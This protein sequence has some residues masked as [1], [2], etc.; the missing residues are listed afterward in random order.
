[1]ASEMTGRV[2]PGF[3][4]QGMFARVGKLFSILAA[5]PYRRAFFATRTAAATEHEVILAFTSPKT[6][7]DVGANKGQFSLAVR[8]MLPSA[9]IIAFEVLPDALATYRKNFAH[10]A[11][12]RVE[13]VALSDRSG[14]TEFFVADRRDSSSLLNVGQAQ[15]DIFGVSG[16]GRITVDT[17][18]LDEQEDLASLSGPILLKIDVQGAELMVLEGATQSLKLV[19]HVYVECS[20]IE[21]YEGQAL[22]TDVVD[23]LGRQGFESCGAFNTHFDP[24]RGPIQSDCLF[25]RARA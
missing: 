9:Q 11:A 10:D 15:T 22:L 23:F 20:Y 6:V 13:P 7:I 5:K 25:R 24:V 8:R 16:T 19:D 18:R 4:G 1:M 17:V 3:P 2:A 12:V 21:L 14:S